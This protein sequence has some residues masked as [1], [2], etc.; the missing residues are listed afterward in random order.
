M[1]YDGWTNYETW[2]V[3]TWIYNDEYY[4]NYWLAA[5]KECEYKV[6]CLADMMREEF[7]EAKPEVSDMW[8]DLLNSAFGEIN[9]DETAMVMISNAKEVVDEDEIINE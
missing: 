9:W 3:N 2:V 4:Y 6:I 1:G 8:G 5:A 7:E